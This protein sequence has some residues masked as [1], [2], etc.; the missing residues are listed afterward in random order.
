MRAEGRWIDKCLQGHTLR[1]HYMYRDRVLWA[2]VRHRILVDGVPIHQMARVIGMS[3]K[4]IRKMLANHLPKPYGPRAPKC[5]QR[6]AIYSQQSSVVRKR[7]GP[8]EAKEVAFE[9]MRAVL[10][11][12][13]GISALR[14]DVG[15]LPELQELT[16]RL[17]EG[18]LSERN[19]SLVILANRHGVRSSLACRFLAIN[20]KTARKYIRKFAHAG[21]SGLF[22][23]QT[24]SNRKFD[25]EAIK[26]AVFKLLH[27][28]PSNYGIN[29]TTWTMSHLS[30]ILRE[31]S[32][33]VSAGVIRKIT[34]TAGYRWRKAR[35]VACTRFRRHRVRCFYG[36]R[37]GSWRD[38]GLRESSSLK[39]CG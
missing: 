4:T 25:D 26:S 33:P 14:H 15:D 10:Q 29:R 37:G 39:L 30:R 5:P 19:R 20:R 13:I 11:R 34:K 1:G 38:V 6:T 17:Y 24:K 36:T 21:A 3:R 16:R 35:I 27:E 28:P 2:K 12:E 31:T 32:R 9:W 18:R 8:L 23:P 22:A 7:S